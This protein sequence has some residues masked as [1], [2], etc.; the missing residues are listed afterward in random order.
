MTRVLLHKKHKSS[1]QAWL[2]RQLVDPYVAQSK[3]EGYRSRAAYKLIQIQEQFKCI[4][5]GQNILDVGAAPGSWSQYLVKTLGTTGSLLAIDLLPMEH[6]PNTQVIQGDF[7]DPVIQIQIQQAGPFHGIVS[8]ASPNLTGQRDI[9]LIRMKQLLLGMHDLMP[10]ALNYG[11]Y[12]IFKCFGGWSHKEILTWIG[13]KSFQRFD[14]FKPAASRSDS[15][16]IYGIAQGY[17]NKK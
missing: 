16:E 15:S 5:P 12:W 1:S 14:L 13:P 11:G 3:Q 6:L 10:Q 7:F 9:D 2:K 4:K 8:D 17:Q